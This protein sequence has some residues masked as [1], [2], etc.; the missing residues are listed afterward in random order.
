MKA[1][2][3]FFLYIAYAIPSYV[4]VARPVMNAVFIAYPKS[5]KRAALYIACGTMWLL[6]CFYVSS[7]IERLLV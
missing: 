1:L 4:A 6:S 5:A 7:L 3:G 2:F